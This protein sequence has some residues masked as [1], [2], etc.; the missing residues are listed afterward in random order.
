M[1]VSHRQRA[2]ETSPRVV[3]H[4]TTWEELDPELGTQAGQGAVGGTY[5]AKQC[6]AVSTQVAATSTPPHRGCPL[7]CSL[8]SQGQAPGGAALPPTMRP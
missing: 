7:S 3:T 8:T 1:G 6:A 2:A 4:P 5:P